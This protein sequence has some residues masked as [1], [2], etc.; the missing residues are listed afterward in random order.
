GESDGQAVSYRS[1]ARERRAL[2]RGSTPAGAKHERW[3][4]DGAGARFRKSRRATFPERNRKFFPGAGD[5]DRSEN[6]RARHLVDLAEP[7]RFPASHS[8]DRNKRNLG[9]ARNLRFVQ[10]V[11]PSA[12]RSASKKTGRMGAGAAPA[13]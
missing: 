12:R 13:I 1:F 10:F 2:A 5:L 8:A 9:R 3:L 7:F 11:R 6:N 4:V